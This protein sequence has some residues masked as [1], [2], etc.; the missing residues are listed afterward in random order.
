MSTQFRE[1]FFFNR[2]NPIFG[3]DYTFQGNT[4]KSLLSI[5]FDSREVQEHIFR[6]RWNILGKYSFLTELK[7]GEKNASSEAAIERNYKI[8]YFGLKP[9][10]GYQYSTELRWSF[11]YSYIHQ[12]NLLANKE[13]SNQQKLSA[14]V[15]YNAGGKSSIQ[16]QFN[17]IYNDFTGTSNSAIAYEMLEALQPGKNLTWSANWQKNIGPSLQLSILYDGRSSE[18]ARVVHAGSMQVRAFF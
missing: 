11:Y 1:T 18:T 13:I 10:I 2:S 12:E 5:G 14:E 17:F 7:N 4:N 3:M 15:K 6:S 16:T 9:E 8:Q